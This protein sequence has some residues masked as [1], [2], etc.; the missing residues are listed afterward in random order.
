MTHRRLD[1]LLP[2]WLED[3][4]A[5]DQS[6][7]EDM[8]TVY[9]TVA[10]NIVIFAIFVLF[11]SWYRRY[12]PEIY[13]PKAKL[14][15]HRTPP[16][17][18]NSTY[19]GWIKEL[20]DIDDDV[21][22]KK[23][24]YDI[25]FFI[26]F[27]RLA[28]RIFIYFSIYAWGVLLPINWSA[29]GDSG[30]N[31]F[32]VWS[33]TN[34][35]QGSSRCWYHLIGIYLLTGSTIY[36]LEQEFVVFTKHRHVYLR[37]RHAHLR[38]VLV[39][40]IPHKMRSTVTLGTYFETLYPNAI[41]N[42][43]LGQDLRYLDRLVEQRRVAVSKLERALYANHYGNKRPTVSVG[44]MLED[45]DAIRYYTQLLDDLNESVAKE[46]E[47]AGKMAS[48]LNNTS[49]ATS[50]EVIES[51]LK[52][53]E[54]GAIKRLLKSKNANM[55]WMGSRRASTSQQGSSNNLEMEIETF[56]ESPVVLQ[57]TEPDAPFK[58]DFKGYQASSY[59]YEETKHEKSK[60]DKMDR[61]A[62]NIRPL[63]FYR[64][65]C[66][67]WI[68]AMWTAPSLFECWRVLKEGRH[69]EDHGDGYHNREDEEEVYLIAPPE[70]RRMFL[71]KAF[72]TFKTFTAATMARQVVHMQLAGHLA[73]SEAPESTDMTWSNLYTT[74]TELFWRQFIV[75]VAVLLLIIVWVAPV[76]LLSF[77]TSE[78]AIRS[79]SPLIDKWCGNA[80][81]ESLIELIQPAAL[82]GIMNILPPVLTGLGIIEGMVSFS[83]NQFRSF[84]RYFTFQVINVFLVT[85][86][87]GS[88]IDCIK[89]IYEDPS[90]AFY[91]LGNSLPKMGGFF[92]NYLIMKAFTG[93]GMEITR[94]PAAFSAFFKWAFTSNV[95]PRDRNEQVLFGSVRSLSNPGWFPFAKIYAQ[96]TLLVVVCC[97]YAC[98]APLILIA[99]LCYFAGAAYVYKHQML[100]VYEPIFETGGK[101]WPRMARCIV[102]ALMFAQ[103]TMIGMMILKETYTEIYFLVGI[104]VFTSVYFWYVNKL[105]VPLAMQ[106]PLDMAVSMDLEEEAENDLEGVEGYTQPSLRESHVAPDVEFE[107]F[108]EKSSIAV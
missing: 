74:R 7:N 81:F 28:F 64:M 106:L 108:P 35:P 52:V 104:L 42:V 55:K 14:L 50:I 41:A 27:Y 36:F 10:V 77:V 75:E 6:I 95:T 60:Y 90:S 87:A 4:D 107:F 24:G 72:V 89:D 63:T 100:Y 105:Y 34:I 101:W 69:M 88:V 61:S 96:D 99:G 31:S 85:T 33:M 18:S 15:P 91:L 5:Y 43:K 56:T 46:Q 51:F 17:L 54:I 9:Y 29:D 93:L 84:D 80:W 71:S 23:G 39:E 40:G 32:E 76:T 2:K 66:A 97:T 26:R 82:V 68:W 78:D 21:L 98:I 48:N 37:Q 13:A 86:I 59:N 45:V 62:S 20:Y 16:L 65:S 12:H 58:G 94:I 44:N 25:L 47:S 83:A 22:I 57:A 38:T 1:W 8:V 19:F 73:I 53:T 102:V 103:A 67:E 30:A 70:E 49:K 79:W 3:A 11:F 92:T